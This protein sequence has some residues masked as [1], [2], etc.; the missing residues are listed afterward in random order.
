MASGKPDWNRIVTVQGKYDDEW[1]PM[2]VDATGQLYIAM[3]AQQIDVTQ[4]D[5]DRNILGAD[6]AT[7]RY[8][9]VDANGVMLSRMKGLYAGGLYDI[10]IDVNGVMLSRMQGQYDG[11][12]KDV[13]LDTNGK[14][15]SL[16][17]GDDDGT[18]RTLYVDA[19]GK[20]VTRIQGTTGGD[21]VVFVIDDCGD[22]DDI[23]AWGELYDGL[24]PTSNEVYVRE[25]S[26][27][28]KLGVD[29]DESGADFAYW[30]NA[31]DIG[32]MNGFSDDTIKIYVYLNSID[33]LATSGK[34]VSYLIGS[35][36]ADY[37]RFDYTKAALT[38][39]WNALECVIA[40]PTTTNGTIDWNNIDLQSIMIFEDTGNTNDFY[41]IVDSLVVVRDNPDPGLLKDLNTDANGFLLSRMVGSFGDYLKPLACDRYG[42]LQIT[43]QV[44][45]AVSYQP[46]KQS[47]GF[48]SNPTSA[49]HTVLNVSAPGI[50]TG[51]YVTMTHS[52][53]K[54]INYFRVIINGVGYDLPT[55]EEQDYRGINEKGMGFIHVTK[56][57]DTNFV[58]SFGF[59]T[60]IYWNTS[61]WIRLKNVV[62]G[63][64]MKYH[65]MYTLL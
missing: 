19:S 57:D 44:A 17:Q 46:P 22:T 31:T 39:G 60:Q 21:L 40:S 47:A 28:M 65:I 5:A 55:W 56:Y 54:K 29:A 45:S 61:I 9:A 41:M 10:A 53:T 11:S 63:G 4:L 64:E 27:S 43:G 30:D 3:T 59:A 33:Y 20:M 15:I 37:I 38:V 24:D 13:A 26:K 7:K 42:R 51:G 23:S 32:D 52:A 34:A 12:A 49:Y 58:Y 48:V 6:G 50:I 2:K 18:L 25:G 62:V 35:S 1:L 16:M 14:M 36:A 8:I